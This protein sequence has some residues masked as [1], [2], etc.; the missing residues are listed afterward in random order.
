[1][2]NPKNME[3]MIN[4][5]NNISALAVKHGVRVIGV[6]TDR[7]GHT[8]WAAYETPS[9]E[10]FAE[11]EI[12]PEFMARVTFNHIEKKVVTSAEETLDFFTEYKKKSR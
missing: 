1:M 3:V 9:M 4:W 11:L 5:L 2:G 10:A 7:W 12:E 6:W 8:S